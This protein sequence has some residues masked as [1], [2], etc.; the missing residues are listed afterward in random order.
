MRRWQV[1][2]LGANLGLGLCS[3]WAEADEQ[4]GKSAIFA[5][6]TAAPV[7]TQDVA[8]IRSELRDREDSDQKAR[9][10][11]GNM[12]KVDRDNTEWLKSLTRKVGWIDA[13]RFGSEAAMAAFLIV[14]HSDDD[15]LMAAAL[16]DIEKD[17]KAKRLPDGQAYALLYD[18]IQV[19]KGEKQR[20]GSQI[21]VLNGEL[22]VLPL[23]DRK[24]VDA[25][26][27]ELGMPPLSEYLKMFGRK[28]RFIDDASAANKVNH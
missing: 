25:W 10:G 26:R 19:Y 28:V 11:G 16:P 18:R 21:G 6:G 4:K 7:S 27:E 9:T 23:E 8:K 14:Q 20:Y 2:W 3:V 5:F 22:V 13:T 17:V 1:L 15:A 12:D 24:K